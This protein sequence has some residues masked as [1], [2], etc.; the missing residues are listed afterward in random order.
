LGLISRLTHRFSPAGIRVKSSVNPHADI[1]PA[2]EMFAHL[3]IDGDVVKKSETMTREA[4][5]NSWKLKFDY[6]L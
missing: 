2:M 6:K 5:G 3:I 1:P 4:S